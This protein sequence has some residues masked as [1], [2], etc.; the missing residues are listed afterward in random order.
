M[1]LSK[2]LRGRG[3][4]EVIKPRP[5]ITAVR[6]GYSIDDFTI[7]E[8]TKD[9]P[10]SITYQPSTASLS[11]PRK[12]PPKVLNHLPLK[13]RCTYSK[14]GRVVTITLNHSCGKAQRERW[15]SKEITAKYRAIRPRVE[16]IHAQMKH[17][18]N[19]AKLRFWGLTKNTMC[20]LLLGA[21]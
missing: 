5:L 15:N 13:D 3:H 20:Y 12:E 7:K 10:G 19:G 6:G 1:D 8:T 14:A 16:G 18:L 21:V 17:K 11:P 9:Q 2:H 4:S